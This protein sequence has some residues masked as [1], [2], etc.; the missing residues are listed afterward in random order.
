MLRACSHSGGIHSEAASAMLAGVAP[1]PANSGQVTTRYRLHRYGDRQLDNALRIVL[2]S[3]IHD[4]QA[5]YDDVARR[6]A[7]R[8][9]LVK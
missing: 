6:T 4:Q 7:E 8:R 3:R 2:R 1:I 5:T 9:T